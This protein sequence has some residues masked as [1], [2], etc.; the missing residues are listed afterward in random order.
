MP[1]IRINRN[2][3]IESLLKGTC[4]VVFRKVTDGRFRAMYCTLKEEKLPN[5]TSKYIRR[6]KSPSQE[7]DIDL[8]PVYDIIKRDWRSFRIQ[9][10]EYFYDTKELIK[11]KEI[12]DENR[13]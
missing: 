10:I 3:I 4:K 9:N 11:R 6:I 2:I 8:L 7:D 1:P 5:D 12:R 13:E